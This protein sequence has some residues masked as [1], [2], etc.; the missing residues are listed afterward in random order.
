MKKLF[1]AILLNVTFFGSIYFSSTELLAQ[2]PSPSSDTVTTVETTEFSGELVKIDGNTL[3]IQVDDEI[4]VVNVSIGTSV[5]R[6]TANVT[7]S[8]LK[9]GDKLTVQ[10][11]SDSQVVSVEGVDGGIFDTSKWLIP[12]LVLIAMAGVVGWM[13]MKKENKSHIKTTVS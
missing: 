12:L 10:Q 1:A 5:K 2:S 9:P 4:K 13:L 8:E 3:S 6:N 11:T 7:L